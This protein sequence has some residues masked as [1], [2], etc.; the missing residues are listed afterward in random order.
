MRV[1]AVRIGGRRRLDASRVF[2][3]GRSQGLVEREGASREEAQSTVSLTRGMSGQKANRYANTRFLSGFV[4]S[5][6]GFRLAGSQYDGRRSRIYRHHAFTGWVVGK[7]LG[8]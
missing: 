4:N 8:T 3:A 6:C 1:H 2:R 5:T 7:F